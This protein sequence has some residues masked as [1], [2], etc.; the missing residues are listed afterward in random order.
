MKRYFLMFRI[1]F[2]IG[3]INI[4]LLIPSTLKAQL[5]CG[6]PL[7]QADCPVDLNVWFLVL[8]VVVLALVARFK[9]TKQA[10]AIN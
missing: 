7:Q 8:G 1:V 2:V 4:L 10:A 9:K 6:D 3:L 5:N